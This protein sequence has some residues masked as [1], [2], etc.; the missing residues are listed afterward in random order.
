MS[1]L[2][3]QL[4]ECCTELLD[5]PIERVLFEEGHLSA[6]AGLVLRDGREVV[7]KLRPY[8]ERVFACVEVQRL[9]HARGFPCPEPIAGPL[10]WRGLVASVE[11]LVR[12]GTQLQGPHTAELYARQLERMI[13]LAPMPQDVGSLLP[14]PPW[15]G[16]DHAE[17]GVWPVPDDLD[18]DL[19]ADHEVPW[20]DEVARQVRDCLRRARLPAVV[21]HS[22]WESQN[23]RWEST[24]LLVVH[25]WDSVVVLPE[26]AIAGAASAVFTATGHELTEPPPDESR[27]FLDAYARAR[28]RAWAAEETAVA[29]AAGLWVRAFNAKKA[30]VRGHPDAAQMLSRFASE[31]DAR[32]PFIGS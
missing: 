10:A 27:E 30:S 23:L 28:G 17:A 20:L 14:Q 9:L 21:G 26:A 7:L 31:L 1:T 11:T 19:N 24:R 8:A 32:M 12:G 16:W 22:D 13:R 5:S 6:V 25:D 2:S 15:V 29:W 18:A 3:K 4:E